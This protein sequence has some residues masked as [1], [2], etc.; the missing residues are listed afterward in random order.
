MVG[1]V[2]LQPSQKSTSE[3]DFLSSLSNLLKTV[4]A[5]GAEAINVAL[6]KTKPVHGEETTFREEPY[7][8][9]EAERVK[10]GVLDES[11]YSLVV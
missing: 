1:T 2:T 8:R 6:F 11:K 7:E 4:Q 3:Y 5:D 9:L 10:V